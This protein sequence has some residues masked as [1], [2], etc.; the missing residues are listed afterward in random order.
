MARMS[1]A[2][3]IE[4]L[5][6]R[7]F[8]LFF[9]FLTNEKKSYLLWR[10]GRS[11]LWRRS[12]GYKLAGRMS[13]FAARTFTCL[14]RRSGTMAA[15]KQPVVTRDQIKD[16]IHP[17]LLSLSFFLFSFEFLFNAAIFFLPRSL[18]EDIVKT[19]LETGTLDA[20]R[21]VS[22]YRS[23][24]D[25]ERFCNLS[26]FD[27]FEEEIRGYFWFM[28]MVFLYHVISSWN[29]SYEKFCRNWNRIRKWNGSI[30][31]SILTVVFIGHDTAA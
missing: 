8:F 15:A 4:G 12:R 31:I 20:L 11:S 30:R 19:C 7:R 9:F 22:F 29:V 3:S 5:F 28:S 16:I 6:S 10:Q 26:T 21:P 23:S 17:S 25:D 14:D 24:K 27:Q 13:G 2:R 1:N 18:A